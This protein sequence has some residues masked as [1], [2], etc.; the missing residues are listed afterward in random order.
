[1]FG[2]DKCGKT[3][4]V[5]FILQQRNPV[6]GI[7]EEKHLETPPRVK[8]DK[9]SHLYTLVLHGSNGTYELFVDMKSESKGPLLSAMKPP[10]QVRLVV[11]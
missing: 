11:I 8:S 5:H 2:P 3:D 6:T 1:M 10:L 4:K 9:L 7:W